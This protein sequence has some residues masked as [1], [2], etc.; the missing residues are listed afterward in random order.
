MSRIIDGGQ[1][2]HDD[3]NGKVENDSYKTGNLMIAL[4]TDL[5]YLLT[6]MRLRD[7]SDQVGRWMSQLRWL[8]GIS[9][10]LKT[11]RRVIVMGRS[12]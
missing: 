12:R 4:H 6:L 11:A 7:D 2:E 1:S 9:F 8:A 5:G 10:L 3:R